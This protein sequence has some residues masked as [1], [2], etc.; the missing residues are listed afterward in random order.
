[1]KEKLSLVN[2]FLFRVEY[3]KESDLLASFCVIGQTKPEVI[4]KL[5]EN[6]PDESKDDVLQDFD[7]LK[8]D[9]LG[10]LSD[11]V[12]LDKFIRKEPKGK[13]IYYDEG[14]GD[15][16]SEW[17]EISKVENKILKVIEN[18][19]KTFEEIADDLKDENK[20]IVRTYVEALATNEIISC[21][22]DNPESPKYI[23]RNENNL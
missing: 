15:F 13:L 14:K 8:I 4:K 10:H 16:R 7:N 17:F 22:Y 11:I 6:W 3:F 18:S 2:Y 12:G 19:E 21:S 1:M 20:V 5:Q 23:Y 9:N